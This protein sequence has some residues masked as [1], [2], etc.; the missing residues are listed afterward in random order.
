[1]KGRLS[2][3]GALIG[4]GMFVVL[5]QVLS[6]IIARPIMPPPLEVL[7]MFITALVYD[8]RV[9]IYIEKI[10]VI[11]INNHLFSYIIVPLPYL[12]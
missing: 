12:K 5:W 8:E 7:P 9:A 3:K 4:F 1:M 10:I 6:W 2:P 11:S